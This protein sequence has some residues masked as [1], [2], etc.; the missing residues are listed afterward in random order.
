MATAY[1]CINHDA[2]PIHQQQLRVWIIFQ[3][4]YSFSYLQFEAKFAATA[5]TEMLGIENSFVIRQWNISVKYARVIELIYYTL[6]YLE[7]Y[8]L[9]LLSSSLFLF[10]ELHFL[11]TFLLIFFELFQHFLVRLHH[12]H[13]L[14]FITLSLFNCLLLLD[15]EFYSTHQFVEFVVIVRFA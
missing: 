11:S 5:F 10:W 14:F 6:I 7:Y 15:L 13:I 9:L 3:R 12:L 1:T 4:K 8:I 2:P